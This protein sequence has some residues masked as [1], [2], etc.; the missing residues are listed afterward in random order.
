MRLAVVFIGSE[1][2]KLR[3]GSPK[4]LFLLLSV[5][6]TLDPSHSLAAKWP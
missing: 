4:E 1:K 5:S 2:R 6:V 3:L